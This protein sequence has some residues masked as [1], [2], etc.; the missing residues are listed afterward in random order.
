M[1]ATISNQMK[2][3]ETNARKANSSFLT[4]WFLKRLILARSNWTK[5]SSQQTSQN[6]SRNLKPLV[7]P[8]ASKEFEKDKSFTEQLQKALAR[9]NELG[10]KMR[11]D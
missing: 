3:P 7:V 5:K 1:A 10:G 9:Y 6:V 11:I 4:I 2:R 8:A